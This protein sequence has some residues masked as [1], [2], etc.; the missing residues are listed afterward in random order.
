MVSGQLQT[1]VAAAILC[2]L[3]HRGDALDNDAQKACKALVHARHGCVN[4]RF[5]Q[6]WILKWVFRHE[7]WKHGVCFRAVANIEQ[8]KLQ[9]SPVWQ[10]ECNNG[11]ND[12]QIAWP[13]Y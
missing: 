7:L 6:W 12:E 2:I 3:M 11:I 4:C 13:H 5:K 1:R 10:V 9:Q 8:F